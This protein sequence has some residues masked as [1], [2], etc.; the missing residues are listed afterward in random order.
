MSSPLKPQKILTIDIETTG[1]DPWRDEIT[2]VGLYDGVV[3]HCCRTK[4]EY[5]RILFE[6][7]DWELLGHNLAFDVRFLEVKGW[8][9]FDGRVLHDTQLVAHVI[10]QKVPKAFLKRYEEERKERNKSLPKGYTHRPARPLSL[11]VLAPWFLKVPWFWEDP[12]NHDNEEY[13]KK[14]C[15]Y[16][17]QLF[18]HLW[19]HLERDGLD[20]YTRR[21]LPWA[22]MCLDMS[23]RGI[24]L[25]MDRLAT[26]EK[27]YGAKAFEL[28]EKLDVLWA[29]A[30]EQYFKMEYGAL[31]AQYAEMAAKATAKTK[32]P[33]KTAAR[34]QQLL[35]NAAEKLPRKINYQ[36]P[37]QMKWL[38]RDYLKLDI[39]KVD[40]SG[41]EDD[42]EDTE[43][44]G[45]AVLHKL[46]GQGRDDIA[47]F[48]E[49]RQASKIKTAFLPTYQELQVD[50]ILHPTFNITG[51]RT[52]R[53]SSSGPNLQQVPS[54]LYNLFRPRRGLD[55]IIYDLSG[56][57]AALIALYSSDRTLYDIISSGTSIHDYNAHLLF[58]L[59]CPLDQVKERYPRERQ[60]IKNVGFACFYGAGWRRIKTV[61][62]TAGFTITDEEAKTK[63]KTLK[64]AYEN[65]FK[66]HRD[67]TQIFEE[68]GVVENLL[69]RPVMIADPEDAYMRG[70]NSLIQS[71][72]S[73]LNLHA[74]EKASRLW[75]ADGLNAHPLL[76]IH[77]CIVAEAP[78]TNAEQA[79]EILVKCMTDY[80]LE[81]D[82]GKIKLAVEGG[83]SNE[84]TK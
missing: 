60:T 37:D 71:S 2:I 25:D 61:F 28:E 54:K 41:K 15:V 36:S 1:L 14:D 43:S 46:A 35:I 82:L 42:D 31:N 63:L 33:L 52:G 55:F 80:K 39:T 83:V 65:V 12:T 16:T 78:K 38:L 6:Y 49:W 19:P 59:H 29:D 75:K 40:F 10:K 77:D 47:T 50:G 69:G 45:K 58:D 81:C 53:T 13:N 74:C 27:V 11:K 62:Q 4:E 72:A 18:D 23:L 73:D 8:G 56:I 32:D 84:W 48:L 68:G 67:I 21:M 26:A 51:T 44:T 70:F 34:Y 22:R 17:R 57:E 5:N 24:S 76:V 7:K 30:H 3:Y 66:F 64:E 9:N 79:A 20:F